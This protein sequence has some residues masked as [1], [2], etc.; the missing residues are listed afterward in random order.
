MIICGPKAPKPSPT[1]RS[2]TET[3]H[4]SAPFSRMRPHISLPSSPSWMNPSDRNTSQKLSPAAST[5]TRTSRAS[6]ARAGS[7]CTDGRSNAPPWSGAR[8]HSASSG[9]TSRSSPS[10]A[11][12]SRATRRRPSRYAM[13]FSGSGYSSSLTRSGA[14]AMDAGSRSIILGRRCAASRSTALPNPHRTAPAIDPPRSR[15]RT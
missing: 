5:P 2:P 14:G 8:T 15:S 12:T 7:G 10:P 13:W 4:T 3:P 11:R 6:R 1:T 9:R